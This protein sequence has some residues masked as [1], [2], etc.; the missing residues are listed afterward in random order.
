LELAARRKQRVLGSIRLI[1]A[2]LNRGM[3]SPR[4]LLS[5]ANELLKDPAA[6]DALESLAALLTAV[7]PTFDD[8]EWSNHGLLCSV[9]D[10]VKA[11]TKDKQVAPR[12]RFLLSDVLDLRATK[13]AN[14]KKVTAKQSGPMKL[15]EVQKQVEKEEKAKEEAQKQKNASPKGKKSVKLEPKQTGSPKQR[16]G[17][18]DAKQQRSSGKTAPSTTASPSGR[19]KPHASPVSLKPASS[20]VAS[21]PKS[22][23]PIASSTESSPR[24]GPFDLRAF[25]REL[26]DV[27]KELGA[28]RDTA[29]ARGRFSGL[30]VPS[31]LQAREFSNLLTRVAEERCSASRRAMFAFIAGLTG[32]VFDKE[33]CAEGTKSFFDDVFDD[34]CEE[35][36]RLPEI[37]KT[38]FVPTIR[39]ALPAGALCKIMPAALK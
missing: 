9:F 24:T 18:E 34:L 38:E 6:P 20:P 33:M 30:K 8:E 17:G 5:C 25:R 19:N 13:W 29:K 14:M 3:L 7:G 28:T 21:S 2:L 16:N 39:A 37:L 31:N 1:G 22:S 32:S 26:T 36:P 10:R 4:V 27:L 11:L 12:L 23:S 35:V 15:E